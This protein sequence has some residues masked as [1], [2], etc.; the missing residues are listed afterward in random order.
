MPRLARGRP[1]VW[2]AVFQRAADNSGSNIVGA[3]LPGA[4]T[5]PA[6][7]SDE[8]VNG[9]ADCL[10]VAACAS[11]PS[12]VVRDVLAQRDDHHT[13]PKLRHA[14]IGSV[15]KMPFGVVAHLLKAGLELLSIVLKDGAQDTQD[16]FNHDGA[17]AGDIDQLKGDW[18]QVAFVA[19]TKLLASYGKGAGRGGRRLAIQCP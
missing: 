16:I 15:Q 3:L 6:A 4:R 1:K 12:E 9:F 8:A 17:R 11:W 7:L 13:W 14:E 2:A 10:R 18:E 19:V 5:F